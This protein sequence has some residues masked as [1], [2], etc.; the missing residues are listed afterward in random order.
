MGQDVPGQE[1]LDLFQKLVNP[2]GFPLQSLLLA[3]FNPEE[4]DRK[5][6]ELK[7]V[8]NWLNANLGLLELT[9]KTL[10]YQKSV[11][12]PAASAAG[13]EPKPDN[14]LANPALWPWGF[15]KPEAKAPPSASDSPK[16]TPRKR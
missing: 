6:A 13:G 10:E 4:I 14:P 7:A 15:A 8:Q 5:I 2:L 16:K 12:T 9:I 1:F 3:G 11:L